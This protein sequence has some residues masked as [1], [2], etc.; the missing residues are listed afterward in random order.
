LRFFVRA[1]IWLLA[2]VCIAASWGADILAV[3]ATP[4]GHRLTGSLFSIG[5]TI[6]LLT[7]LY[8]FFNTAVDRHLHRKDTDGQLVA[9]SARARTLL[10]MLRNTIFIVFAV[11][12]A[13]VILSE[14]GVNIGPLLAGA[15]VIGVA[16]GF[17]SQTLVK[18]FLT[19]L[20]IVLEGAIAVG[21]VVKVGANHSGVVEAMSVRTLRLR[22]SDGAV[23]IL[24]YS[25]VSQIV[26]M[27][28]DF[29]Y[30]LITVGVAYNSDLRHVMEVIKAV[31]ED[32]QQDAK[33]KNSIIDPIEVL[34]VDSFGDSAIMIQAR[35]RTR[36]GR[37]WDVKRALLLHLKERF[38]VEKIEI[39]YPTVVQLAR[40]P[41]DDG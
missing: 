27:T 9:A 22:D 7:L 4:F 34:G 21:D 19:G 6:V 25:E 16:I 38:D 2:G 1:A 11:V 18:D 40:N 20:F 41:D 15:G 32:L 13:L 14:L 29:A 10:P 37:Q 5:V 31:G 12:V 28:K 23:H 8:R 24:P 36:S 3:L 35:I 26:N 33:L 39:P 17:G 30:A